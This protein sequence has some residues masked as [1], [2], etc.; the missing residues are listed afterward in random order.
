MEYPLV[1]VAPVPGVASLARAT[2]PIKEKARP[3]YRPGFD[4]DALLARRQ[5]KSVADL[6]A[7]ETPL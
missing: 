6:D 4:H 7:A 5:I 3:R 1:L 2:G